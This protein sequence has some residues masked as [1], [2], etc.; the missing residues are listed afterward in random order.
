M[1]L[2]SA[3]TIYE[4]ARRG[5]YAVGGFDA[6]HMDMVKAIVEAAEELRA[7]VIVMLW[8]GDI[9]CAGEGYLE[10]LVKHAAKKTTVPIALQVDHG[11][12]VEFC[13][14]S[15]LSGHSSVMI[16]GS[17][18]PF[19]E[20]VALTKQV[21]D[22]CHL[23]NVMVEGEVGTIPR[24][25]ENDGP[26][27]E[28]K[29]LTE[30][31]EAAEFVRLTGI[32]ALAISIGTESG[33][34]KEKPRLDFERLKAIREVTDAYL[35]L[36]G[37]S[38]TPAEQIRIAVQEGVVGIRFATELRI[39]FYD[40]MERKRRELGHDFPDSR[41]MLM[42]AREAAKAVVKEKMYQMGCVGQACTDG[43]CP[44]IYNNNYNGHKLTQR[45]SDSEIDRI[46]ELVVK[47]LQNYGV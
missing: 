1:P 37:G 11:T 33:L 17:H 13:L 5:G 22:I 14:R 41:K 6:E 25:F 40:T 23:M 15:V 18:L 32:D 27:S 43:L 30:P 8:E 4:R 46:V 24:T 2:V 10:A 45:A 20:N 9:E 7:P 36:H 34:Y 31:G 44:P 16:D 47:Q 38:G 35:I 42:P 21:V 12:S 29:R 19:D 39:A 3:Q 26:Y 28:E